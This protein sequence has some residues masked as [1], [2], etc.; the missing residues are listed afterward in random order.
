MRA[1]APALVILLAAQFAVARR[2]A[3]AHT[4]SS[5]ASSNQIDIGTGGWVRAKARGAYDASCWLMKPRYNCQGDSRP[6][7]AANYRWLL[8]RRNEAS[9]PATAFDGTLEGATRVASFLRRGH[10]GS[11]RQRPTT[12]LLLGNSFLRQIFESL[13]CRWSTNITAG[14]ISTGAPREMEMVWAQL[15]KLG[16]H[17]SLSPHNRNLTR[18][19]VSIANGGAQVTY[20]PGCHGKRDELAQYYSAPPGVLPRRAAVPPQELDDCNDD[21]AVLEFGGG[22]GR[23]QSSVLK[24]AFVFRPISYRERLVE[25]RRVS[26]LEVLIIVSKFCCAYFLLA[27]DHRPIGHPLKLSDTVL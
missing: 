14:V 5:S 18:L 21:A 16:R 1:L 19:P 12:L 8:D 24:V 9:V 4:A 27:W 7:Q 3:S 23:E 6:E 26:L 13:A 25:V 2:T 20:V 22:K 10:C 11:D 15:S 17:G